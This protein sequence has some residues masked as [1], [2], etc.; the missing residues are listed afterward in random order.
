MIYTPNDM[1]SNLQLAA[2][3]LMVGRK[4]NQTNNFKISNRC[5]FI[6]QTLILAL[7]TPN[8]IQNCNKKTFH[9]L[10]HINY[11]ILIKFANDLLLI[12]PLR[13]K[14]IRVAPWSSG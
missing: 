14:T 12:L 11:E 8:H 1:P 7:S 13:P 10:G 3:S 2:K 5:S 6:E 9:T 4:N